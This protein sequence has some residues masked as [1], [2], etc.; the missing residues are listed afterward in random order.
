MSKNEKQTFDL[1]EPFSNNYAN[2]INQLML[3]YQNVSRSRYHGASMREHF[4]ALKSVVEYMPPKGKAYMANQYP[5]LKGFQWEEL[6]VELTMTKGVSITDVFTVL[7]KLFETAHSWI[8]ENIL[9][10]HLEHGKPAYGTA[11]HLGNV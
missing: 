11:S 3:N 4:F 2:A 7:D 9:Q 6:F 8:W 5:D 10:F 1:D